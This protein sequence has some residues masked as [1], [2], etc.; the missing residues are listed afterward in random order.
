MVALPLRTTI[1]F[2]LS[3][4]LCNIFGPCTGE[5]KRDADIVVIV[6]SQD[7]TMSSNA[8]E[9]LSSSI[10]EQAAALRM[11]TPTV[12][13]LHKHWPDAV[14]A[15]TMF[16]LFQRLRRRHK[17]DGDWFFFCDDTTGVDLALLHR[18]LRGLNSTQAHFV[19]HALRDEEAT[20]VHHFDE[21]RSLAYPDLSAGMALSKAALQ[22]VAEALDV[23]SPDDFTIDRQYEVAKFLKAHCGGLLLEHSESF[24][25]GERREGCATWAPLQAPSCAERVPKD[26]LTVAVKTCSQFHKDRVPVIRATWA[27]DAHRVTFFSDVEDERVPTVSVGVANVERGHCAKTMAILRHVMERRL[28]GRWLLLADDDTLISIPRLLDL[29]SCFDSEDDVAL[30]ERYGYAAATER[31]YDY[32]TGGS[33]M[34]F[35]RKTVER[36]VNSGCSCPSDDSPDDMI[37]GVCLQRLGIPTTHSPLFHQARPEDYS[38][39]LLSHQRPISFHKFWMMDPIANYRKWLADSPRSATTRDEL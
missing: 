14:G 29:L 4:F 18:T 36:I 28:L 32:L 23:T 12:Y 3:F 11:V 26:A 10:A 20:I 15:W 31:G 1:I 22:R 33:G 30:G 16:P 38:R 7:S 35:S 8:A 2:S 5:T 13:M 34:V 6:L 37:L 27:G 24:C 39:Q 19:G 9:Q 17:H 25:L 21:A